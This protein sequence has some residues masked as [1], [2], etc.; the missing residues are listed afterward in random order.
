[1]PFAAFARE[2][3]KFS[4]SIAAG[5][6]VTLKYF[7][8]Q[9]QTASTIQYPRERDLIPPRHRGIHYLETERCVMCLKCAEACPVD[10]IAIE[11]FRDADGTFPGGH[12]GQKVT[13]TKFTVDYSVCIFCGLCEEPCPTKCIHLGPEYDFHARDR[14]SL[15]KDLLA[16]AVHT[17]AGEAFARAAREELARRRL[18]R[19]PGYGRQGPSPGGGGVDP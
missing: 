13:L 14:R 16:D 17:E 9:R 12:R 18:S 8:R 10:C 7:L 2:I 5:M 15:E 4:R 1:M 3:W 11:G 6:G 19:K